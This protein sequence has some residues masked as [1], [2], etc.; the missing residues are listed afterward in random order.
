MSISLQK[1]QKINLVKD[2]NKINKVMVGLG[3]D[4]K[5]TKSTKTKEKQSVDCD[6]S[7]ILC[8]NG[9]LK[10]FDE[11]VI[12]YNNLN[13]YTGAV[14]HQGDNLSGGDGVE[15]D[16]QI[17]IDLSK[18]P[19]DYDKVVFVVTMYKAKEKQQSFGLI[20]SAFIRICDSTTETELCNF[21]LADDECGDNTALILGEMNR[22]DGIWK[23]SA[24]GQGVNDDILSIAKRYM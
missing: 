14:Q 19:A 6:A 12:F 10:A 22:E 15:D 7:V 11:D 20:K 18:L 24:I 16:E 4:E 8:R 13:H 9:K 17:Y 5:K 23:F 3:W 2:D 1:G 21:N